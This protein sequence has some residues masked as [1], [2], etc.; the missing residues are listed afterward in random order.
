MSDDE[1]TFLKLIIFSVFVIIITVLRE[2]FNKTAIMRYLH[3]H[4]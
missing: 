1:S 4:L 2:F 3:Y